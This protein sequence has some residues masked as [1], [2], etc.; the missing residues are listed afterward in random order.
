MITARPWWTGLATKLALTTTIS[1]LSMVTSSAA[2]TDYPASAAHTAAVCS[3][4]VE[5]SDTVRIV[6][7]SGRPVSEAMRRRPGRSPS[8]IMRKGWG[9]HATTQKGLAC[10]LDHISSPPFRPYCVYAALYRQKFTFPALLG[11]AATYG[12]AAPLAVLLLA[13]GVARTSI[14][15]SRIMP[16]LLD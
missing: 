16:Q 5:E 2:A 4:M 10:D 1:A 11:L 13:D 8:S 6:P 3:G 7:V 14:L 12:L 9:C 15:L